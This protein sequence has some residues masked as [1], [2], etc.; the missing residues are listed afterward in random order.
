MTPAFNAVFNL[1]NSLIGAMLYFF[2]GWFWSASTRR[3]SFDLGWLVVAFLVSRG[4]SY[5][6][7]H[8]KLGARDYAAI[9]LPA[10]P[11]FA[12]EWLADLSLHDFRLHS[13]ME[14]LVRFSVFTCALLIF[15]IAATA[16]LQFGIGRDELSTKDSA[17]WHSTI[18]TGAF[19]IAISLVLGTLMIFV[20][21][22]T[23]SDVQASMLQSWFYITSLI[24]YLFL[25]IKMMLPLILSRLRAVFDKG[26]VRF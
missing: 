16:L 21:G 3:H 18:L 9:Y 1:V 12:L 7:E 5:R 26:D 2:V 19:A 17:T 10:V 15:V 23:K 4:V 22:A 14:A 11:G 25:M 24:V 8:G 6:I 20:R 13:E